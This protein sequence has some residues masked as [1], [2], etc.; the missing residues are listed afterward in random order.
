MAAETSPSL[1]LP[2][3]LS[4]HRSFL[5]ALAR[6]LLR[7][8]HAAE[9]VAQEA[10][11]AAL[12]RSPADPR[13]WLTRVATNLSFDALRRRRRRS[14][15]ERAAARP[16]SVRSTADVVA[17]ESL[18]RTV[19]E[20]VLALAE[21][22]RS[23][24]LLRFYDGL[25]PR[26]MA[27]RLGVPAET[28]RTRVRRGLDQLRARLDG[29]HDGKRT[30]WAPALAVEAMRLGERAPQTTASALLVGAVAATAVLAV[31]L[32]A[33]RR[34]PEAA[35][36]V[37]R[38]GPP[39]PNARGAA[40][41]AAIPSPPSSERQLASAASRPAE[42]PTG[43]L[44]VRVLD[45]E[46]EPLP[47]ACVRVE[48]MGTGDPRI[49]QRLS[50]TDAEGRVRFERVPVGT[51]GVGCDR[52][53][54]DIV[55]ITENATTEREFTAPPG[56]QV[57]GSVRGWM[58]GPEEGAEIWVSF[59]P[60]FSEGGIA[61]HADADG[62]FRLRDVGRGQY[63]G[64]RGRGEPSFLKPIDGAPETTVKVELQLGASLP[65]VGRVVG[66]DG[67]PVA[68][69]FVRVGDDDLRVL[70]MGTI[71][72]PPAP[73]DSASPTILLVGDDKLA[74]HLPTEKPAIAPRPID[75]RTDAQ[76][77]FIVRGVRTSNT[78]SG[79]R[80]SVRVL[81]RAKGFA[82]WSEEI[83]L[84]APGRRRVLRLT[85]GARIEGKLVDA[86]GQRAVVRVGA[87]STLLEPLSFTDSEGRYVID[88]AA[89][90]RV[91][92]R[93]ETSQGLR[94]T[95][96]LT[97]SA[98]QTVVHDFA[99]ARTPLLTGRIIDDTGAPLP[100]RFVFASHGDLAD[101]WTR[102]AFTDASGRFAIPSDCGGPHEIHVRDLGLSGLSLA[103]R[104]RVRPEEDVLVEL[105]RD[106]LASAHVHATVLDREGLPAVSAEVRL[107]AAAGG[108]MI[109][110]RA[111]TD[112]RVSFGPVPAGSY[113]VRIEIPGT[114]ASVIGPFTV[115]AGDQDL[116]V[117]RPAAPGSL[118]L[119]M[120][121]WTGPYDGASCW[122]DITD[123]F[124]LTVASFAGQKDRYGVPALS[125]GS[126]VV[127]LLAPG[128]ASRHESF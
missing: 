23:A 20:A 35:R 1:S 8:E 86:A 73:S 6:E 119:V 80:P 41:V 33:L 75:V 26:E 63:V 25:P 77:R 59:G 111:A 123:A 114:A 55:E 102:T 15:R 97:V 110:Q 29:L 19:V 72:P 117:I 65:F 116:G 109:D 127:S 87:G 5:L 34:E 56:I 68:E 76:G 22:S 100:G 90:G 82:P 49:A 13:P 107:Q 61:A 98:G 94:R 30:R 113:R 54:G 48:P 85:R 93:A 126:Y 71:E 99:L 101:D 14:D 12:R 11:L 37:A 60:G 78:S 69:A 46:G 4:A 40:N 50:A 31:A 128:F 84:H 2:D 89:P 70:S 95:D 24:I 43:T 58:G 3:A 120:S 47:G 28:A 52:V 42:S 67:E 91:E 88:E 96:T 27:R 57:E 112:G 51:A 103:C 9:D 125:P 21:P 74:Q 66:P 7:D 108:A 17:S 106:E 39:E 81:V 18:R 121:S 118:D 79:S 45:S 62:R 92:L 64:A 10:A 44:V 115:Q 83:P 36:D 16:E 38:L 122:I 53:H 105:A 32:V 124:G 104:E